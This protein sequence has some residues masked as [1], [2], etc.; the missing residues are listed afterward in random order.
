MATVNINL[1]TSNTTAPSLSDAAQP[2]KAMSAEELL[3]ALQTGDVSNKVLVEHLIKLVKALQALC[4]SLQDSTSKKAL[5]DSEIQTNLSDMNVEISKST[6]EELAEYIK[7]LEEAESSSLADDIF[8]VVLPFL[9]LVF[10]PLLAIYP[11]G[12]MSLFLNPDAPFGLGELGKQID[13]AGGEGTSK[14]VTLALEIVVV[15]ALSVVTCGGAGVLKQGM[16]MMTKEVARNIAKETLKNL[17]FYGIG[18]AI[19]EGVLDDYIT[20]GILL[21]IEEASGEE[22]DEATRALIKGIVKVIVQVVLIMVAIRYSSSKGG[23]TLLGNL[24]KAFSSAAKLQKAMIPLM[25]VIQAAQSG[26]EI[27]SGVNTIEIAKI[28]KR[29]DKLQAIVKEITGIDENERKKHTETLSKEFERALQ[30]SKI[31]LSEFFKHR[32]KTAEIVGS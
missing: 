1:R 12:P 15:I 23:N 13:E 21:A 25:F 20:E 7:Q 9:S 5:V 2:E 6:Q 8:G 32:S 17:T 22:I 19:S 24:T 3:I 18:K 16:S 11:L 27:W 26:I 14:W 31:D 29:M 4:V 10:P 28:K 30:A